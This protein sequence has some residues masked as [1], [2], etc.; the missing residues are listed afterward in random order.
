MLDTEIPTYNRGRKGFENPEVQK[1]IKNMLNLADLVTVTTEYI[2]L[3]YNK[4]YGVP[5]ENIICVPNL[6]PR[7]LFDDRYNPNKKLE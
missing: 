1:S 3:A 4:Y 6:L 2:K 7:Y 5:L